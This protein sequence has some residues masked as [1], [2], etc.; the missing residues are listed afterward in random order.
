MDGKALKLKQ[1][2]SD[3]WEEG[4][5]RGKLKDAVTSHSLDAPSLG[6]RI[7]SHSKGRDPQSGKLRTNAFAQSFSRLLKT[8]GK[9]LG[10]QRHHTHSRRNVKPG[11]SCYRHRHPQR[12][13]HEKF[14]YRGIPGNLIAETRRNRDRKSHRELNNISTPPRK[15]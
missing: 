15:R 5:G 14:C 4:E 12:R 11:H 1:C 8:L 9:R 6:W 2:C 3:R 7:L 10:S 13:V